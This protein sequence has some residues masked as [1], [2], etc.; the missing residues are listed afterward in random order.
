MAVTRAVSYGQES[1]CQGPVTHGG[2]VTDTNSIQLLY[3]K[4][5]ERWGCAGRARA[6]GPV[7]HGL[8]D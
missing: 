3:C 2:A 1:V 8:L 5:G 4:D 6:G 7:F